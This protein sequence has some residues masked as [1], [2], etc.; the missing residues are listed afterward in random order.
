[1]RLDRA[2]MR[3]PLRADAARLAEEIA[4]V[5][6]AEWRDHPEGAAGNTALPIVAAGGDPDDDSTKGPMAPTPVLAHLPYTR[7]VLAG[8]G[9]TIGRTRFIRIAKEAGQQGDQC[10]DG[11]QECS[12]R[13]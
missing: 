9:A 12:R 11:H 10:S 5:G 2:L 3:L 4:G 8:L 6:S 13:W 1:M 7:Q